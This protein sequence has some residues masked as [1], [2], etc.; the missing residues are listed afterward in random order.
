[1]LQENQLFANRYRLVKRLGQGAFSE[2]WKAEDT[3]VGNLTVALKVYA[4]D[5][6][7]DE[8]GA[9]I[10]GEEFAIVFN[11]HHQNLL[12][13]ST[14]D[15]EQ[16]SPYLV[17]PF[18]E[19]GSATRLIGIMD[20][21]QVAQ[22]LH[23]VSSALAYLHTKDIVHQDVKPDNIL[24]NED[25]IFLLTNFD[26]STKIG[27]EQRNCAGTPAFMGPERFV[28]NQGPIKA[29]DIWSLGATVFELMTGDVP[30]GDMGGKSQSMG[31]EKP[32]I[33][34]AY[35][36][37]LKSIVGQC[38]SIE[39]WNRPTAAQIRD[40]CEDYL[41]KDEWN[42]PTPP[43]NSEDVLDSGNTTEPLLNKTKPHW[44][45]FEKK[46]F[47]INGVLFEMVHMKGGLFGQE[48]DDFWLSSTVVTIAQWEAVMG[49]ISGLY[50]NC[51]ESGV[52]KST[53]AQTNRYCAAFVEN[54]DL[55]DVFMA[56]LSSLLN[57][58]RF[59]RLPTESEW[60]YAFQCVHHDQ[61]NQPKESFDKHKWWFDYGDWWFYDH[62][63]VHDQH[64]AGDEVP[65]ELGLHRM[66]REVWEWVYDKY[67]PVLDE[68][69]FIE[70]KNLSE[71]TEND[72]EYIVGD[73]VLHNESYYDFRELYMKY[74]LERSEPLPPRCR[75]PF[76]VATFSL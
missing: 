71:L 34:N 23:D 20:E 2:V 39:P 25:G 55:M 48:V 68:Y 5:K 60:H 31:T 37:E 30:F 14:F 43:F 50:L 49:D 66:N 75:A 16:N 61:D 28:N 41:R 46:E 73:V 24:I 70:K 52:L 33:P 63:F 17:L 57:S 10:F 47:K 6:G 53:I 15:K 4:P 35:S 64:F 76:R 74:A 59:L 40:I 19:R 42:L 13:P 44:F 8:D 54:H 1:M 69:V 36:L 21:R 65:D 72:Y 67:V 58:R 27:E 9:K 11:I 51:R 26:I 12:T 45:P 18:C 32:D 62:Y 7:L 56:K 38:L 29:S 3:M 22:F